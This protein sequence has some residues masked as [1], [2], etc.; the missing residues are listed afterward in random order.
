MEFSRYGLG[1]GTGSLASGL[2]D[3][4]FQYIT[5]CELDICKVLYAGDVLPGG[6]TRFLGQ[7]TPRHLLPVH[8]RGIIPPCQL[9]NG[10]CLI[11]YLLFAL[12]ASATVTLQVYQLCPFCRRGYTVDGNM[13]R[14]SHM[15][16][17]I[18]GPPTC[19]HFGSRKRPSRWWV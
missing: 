9:V 5:K 3:T 17:C 1:H 2:H 16:E 8:A 19:K 15:N 12:S 10:T 7:R 18:S 4:S 11:E 13:A 6:T 14:L